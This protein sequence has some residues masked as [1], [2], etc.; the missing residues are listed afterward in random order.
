MSGRQCSLRLWYDV[1]R[2]DLAAKPD[3]AQEWIFGVTST[4]TTASER[5]IDMSSQVE[6]AA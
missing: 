5:F 2:R 6:A 3:E 4:K 1:H